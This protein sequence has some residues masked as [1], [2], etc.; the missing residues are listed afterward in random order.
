MN[1]YIIL[2]RYTHQGVQNIKESPARIDAAKKAFESVGAHL[3]EWYLVFGQYDGVVIGEAPDDE[4][5]AKL[6]LAIGSLGNVRT[7]CLRAFNEGEFR[8]IVAGLP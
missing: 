2:F 6:L 8:K 3:K 1:T 7:E 5:A 4:T